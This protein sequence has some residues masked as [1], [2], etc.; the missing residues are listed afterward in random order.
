MK[1]STVILATVLFFGAVSAA[2]EIQMQDFSDLFNKEDGQDAPEPARIY[3]KFT[4]QIF[5][6]D[7]GFRLETYRMIRVNGRSVR[8]DRAMRYFGQGFQQYSWDSAN[9]YVGIN[10]Y[11]ILAGNTYRGWGQYSRATSAQMP[12]WTT[13][14]RGQIIFVSYENGKEWCRAQYWSTLAG[15]EKAAKQFVDYVMK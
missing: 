10:D 6:N 11:F 7:N 14:R 2:Q 9:G 4:V 8:S 3:K 5:H 12:P 1:I 13:F 15:A